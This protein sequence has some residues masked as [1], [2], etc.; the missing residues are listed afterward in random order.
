[1]LRPNKYQAYQSGAVFTASPAQ[2][3]LMLFEG[4]I[5]FLNIALEGFKREDPLEF[6]LTIH[7]NIQKAQAII[8]ELRACLDPEKGREFAD[9]MTALYDYFD[10]RLQEANLKKVREPVEEVNRHLE[11]LR[12]AWKEMMQKQ[13][14]EAA[15]PVQEAE[16]V[17]Q[18]SAT[19]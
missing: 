17:G 18:W 16:Q 8:R 10:R 2:L 15:S 7:Q 6:N 11:V 1:M 5:K 3:V 9:R 13:S 19:G 12:D 4:T 14:A